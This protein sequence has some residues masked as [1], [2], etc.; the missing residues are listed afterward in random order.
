[1]QNQVLQQEFSQRSLNL[2]KSVKN[3]MGTNEK[4]GTEKTLQK[5][6]YNPFNFCYKLQVQGKIREANSR[7]SNALF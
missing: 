2:K 1:M 5:L 3:N 6:E 7:S 4:R